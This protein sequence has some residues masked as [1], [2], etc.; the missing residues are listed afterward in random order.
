MDQDDRDLL[1]EKALARQV[2]SNEGAEGSSHAG[3]A[4]TGSAAGCPDAEAIAVFH[5][6]ALP[7]D[8]I[9]TMQEH[10]AVC[11]RCQETLDL[12]RATDS[13]AMGVGAENLSSAVTTISQARRPKKIFKWVAPAGAIAA[14]LLIWMVV[15]DNPR[16]MY[17][18]RNAEVVQEQRLDDRQNSKGQKSEGEISPYVAQPASPPVPE[19]GKSLQ[20]N[21]NGAPS[22]SREKR[23]L[24]RQDSASPGSGAGSLS[25][26]NDRVNSENEK[27][28]ARGLRQPGST[29]PAESNAD[30]PASPLGLG[31]KES[32]DKKATDSPAAA[33]NEVAIAPK[34]EPILGANQTSLE[35]RD[36]LSKQ[37]TKAT[38][39]SSP[40]ASAAAPAPFDTSGAAKDSAKTSPDE[41]T[42]IET[43][44]GGTNPEIPTETIASSGKLEHS[45]SPGFKTSRL[46]FAPTTVLAPGGIT[47]WRF[48]AGGMI[49][50]SSDGGKTWVR[51][52]SGVA[53]E[54][55]VGSAPSASVCWLAGRGGTI[56]RTT[57]GGDH[58]G[59]LVGPSPGD[60][61]GINA[62]DALHAT[63]VTGEPPARFAT[64]DGGV[65]WAPVKEIR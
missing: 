10:F 65:S 43:D 59:K 36:A 16:R 11:A 20:S 6:R 18:A 24:S 32:Q 38:A 58:W 34:S 23:D 46:K 52:N 37:K 28:S 5:E 29:K 2:R 8:E 3:S 63:L 27:L 4:T 45:S 14:G 31:E 12:L 44:Q 30:A 39:S 13:V 50:R 35:E 56:L 15:R 41:T 40:A 47:Q 64:S 21:L 53:A 9:A 17:S 62:T 48:R 54:L 61:N 49:E 42:I 25:A 26:K 60:I 1:F 22:A 55:L 33:R 57:D 7:V 51:Q 19:K